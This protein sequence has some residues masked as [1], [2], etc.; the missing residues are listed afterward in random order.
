LAYDFLQIVRSGQQ[1]EVPPGLIGFAPN[2]YRTE[3]GTL[4]RATL[5]DES[6]QRI[7]SV[8]ATGVYEKSSSGFNFDINVETI[9]VES[10]LLSNLSKI[11]SYDF[12]I[13][14]NGQG[15]VIVISMYVDL[16]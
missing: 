9:T 1:E 12:V 15:K 10:T 7:A 14:P 3:P 13:L 5:W 4:R 16:H 8:S 2:G 6:G 11:D